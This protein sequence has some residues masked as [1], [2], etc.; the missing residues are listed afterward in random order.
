MADRRALGA[1]GPPRGGLTRM[2]IRH[3]II[4]VYDDL[5]VRYAHAFRRFLETRGIGHTLVKMSDPAWP[6]HLQRGLEQGPAALV[7]IS[8]HAMSMIQLHG[9]SLLD[10]LQ[11]HGIPVVFWNID[12]PVMMRPFIPYT[13]PNLLTVHASRPDWQYWRRHVNG[14]QISTWTE[15][16]GPSQDFAPPDF[17]RFEER[18][19]LVLAPMNVAWQSRSP[20]DVR[21]VIGSLDGRLKNAAE[22]AIETAKADPMTLIGDAVTATLEAEDIQ[23][24][25]PRFNGL[26]RLALYAVQHWRRRELLR[27]LAEVPAIIDGA[28]PDDMKAL[29]QN[30]PARLLSENDIGKTLDRMKRAKMVL[31]IA[32]DSGFWHDRVTNALRAGVVPLVERNQVHVKHLLDGET[33]LMFDYA[34]RPISAVLADATAGPGRR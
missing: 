11:P 15:G 22:A 21:G 17:A 20:D 14:A 3:L 16:V 34:A 33:A 2:S 7:S 6:S 18:S 10:F 29:F 27:Q 24:S 23:L 32:Y 19:I 26:V 1:V 4:V 30:G 31:S 13:H 28:I 25:E 9:K 8:Y 5:I 12:H